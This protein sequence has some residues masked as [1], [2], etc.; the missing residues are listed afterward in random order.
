VSAANQHVVVFTAKETAELVERPADPKPLDP[1]EIAG[2]TLASLVSP[3]T[4]LN[5][6]YLGQKFPAEPGY[7]A[8]FEIDGVGAGVTAFKPGDRVLTT[9]PTMGR[10]ASRQRCPQEAAVLLPANLS[11]EVAVHARL[12]NVSMT[13]LTTTVARPPEKVLIMGLGPVGHLASQNFRSCGYDV[14]AVDPSDSRRALAEQK[15]IRAFP[16][17]PKEPKSV[18]ADIALAIDCSGHEQAVLDACKA[19]RKGG[20]V[21]VLG[22]PWKK[23]CDASAHDITNAV[24]RGYVTLR[25]GWEWELPRY[26]PVEFRHGHIFG[27]LKAGVQWLAEGRVRVDGLYETASPRDAQKVYQSLL[28]GTS[29]ALSIVFDWSKV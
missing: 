21:V 18:T 3:G 2:R 9:G 12:M 1:V 27:N 5:G 28:K 8:V 14:I 15:G 10:H 26:S 19:V 17:I 20:E 25:S 6:Q 23:R 22:V 16:S 13:T 4:E 24:Y 11:P 7:A 29:G